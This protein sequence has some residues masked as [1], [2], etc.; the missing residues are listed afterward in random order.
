MKDKI[1]LALACCFWIVTALLCGYVYGLYVKHQTD[2]WW[3]TVLQNPEN[4]EPFVFR[5]G[6]GAKCIVYD[7]DRNGTAYVV[8]QGAEQ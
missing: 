8:C 6:E 5:T 3:R 1:I 4:D 7:M 2:I